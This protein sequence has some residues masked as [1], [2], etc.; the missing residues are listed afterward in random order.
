MKTFAG[1]VHGGDVTTFFWVNRTWKCALADAAMPILTH[2]G[3]ALWN[4]VLALSLLFCTG[5]MWRQ[6]GVF[7]AESLISSHIVVACCKKLLPRQRPYKVLDN[8]S[9]GPRLLMDSSFPSG[10]ATAAFCSATVFSMAFPELT[11]VFYSLAGLVA[12]SRI[13][14]GLHYPSDIVIGAALG[15][16]TPLFFI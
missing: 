12:C 16:V 15:I 11:I 2:I 4:I 14:L 6:T 7:F 13:Y 9:T 1:W 10:H 8:V 5:A 3:G